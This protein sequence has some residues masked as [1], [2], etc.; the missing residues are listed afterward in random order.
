[1]RRFFADPRSFSMALAAVLAALP[2]V[3]GQQLVAGEQKSNGVQA[4][5]GIRLPATA[6]AEIPIDGDVADLLFQDLNGDGFLDLAVA[7]NNGGEDAPSYV[8][9]SRAGKFLKPSWTS[10][11]ESV[12]GGVALGDLDGDRDPDLV[13]VRYNHNHA[14]AYRNNGKGDFEEEPFWE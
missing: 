4:A 7:A 1:M 10:A 5:P 9:L 13:L 2:L 14:A 12:S 8:F 11:D 6:T 3:H